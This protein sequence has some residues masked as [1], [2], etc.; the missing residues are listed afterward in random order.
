M[1]EHLPGKLSVFADIVSRWLVNPP[2]SA[3]CAKTTRAQTLARD[4][5][6]LRLTQSS[7]FVFPSFDKFIGVQRNAH[8]RWFQ[9]PD[10]G[11]ALRIDR[12]L[13]MPGAAKDLLK[14]ILIVGHCGTRGHRGV[15]VLLNL[16]RREF[17]IDN[18]QRQV[19]SFVCACLLCKHVKARS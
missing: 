9:M 4:I 10:D 19:Q 8:D 2:P 15:H 3:I 17:G 12:K 16:L 6:S 13:W 1:I 11:S 7:G 5:S 14:R 18:I